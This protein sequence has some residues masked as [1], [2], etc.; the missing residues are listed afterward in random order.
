MSITAATAVAA[1]LGQNL[2]WKDT[3]EPDGDRAT[4]DGRHGSIKPEG[5]RRWTM[6]VG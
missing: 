5:R 6:A 4:F 2:I 1:R 3:G